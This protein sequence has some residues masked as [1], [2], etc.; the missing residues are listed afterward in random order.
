MNNNM[1]Q[2]ESENSSSVQSFYNEIKPVLA[3]IREDITRIS[4]N[5]P[6][7]QS[8]YNRIKTSLAYIE[9]EIIHMSKCIRIDELTPV[10]R[11]RYEARCFSCQKRLL[12]LLRKIE[13]A[14][15]KRHIKSSND[16]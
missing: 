3:R 8:F 5:S 12:N 9:E 14:L 4:E 1:S 13:K 2:D 16:D 15:A 11:A 6:S 10:Q 7:M